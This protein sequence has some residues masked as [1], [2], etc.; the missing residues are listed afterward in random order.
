[1]LK[2][3]HI[4]PNLRKGGAERL[5][6]DICIE[7]SKRENIE[8]SLVTLSDENEYRF[9]SDQI[10][11]KVIPSKVTPSISGKPFVQIKKLQNFI[12]EFKPDVIHSHLFEAEIVSRWYIISGIRYFSHCHDNM[13]QL[14]NFIWKD[15]R[16]KKRI[17]ELYE[18]H[19]LLR[20]YSKCCN[21]FIAISKSTESYL[22][23]VLPRIFNTR[24]Y[25]LANA[26]DFKRFYSNSEKKSCLKLISVGRLDKNKN[27][28]FLF[29]VITVLREKIPV[30][31]TICGD[32][33]EMYNLQKI[34]KNN[35]LEEVISLKG[36]V[37][38]V[39]Y[40]LSESTIYV[41]SSKSEALGLTLLEAMASGLPVVTLNGGGNAYIMENGKNGF[42]IDEQNPELFAEKILEIWE[43]EYL[44]KAM[45]KYAQE[46]S[47]HFDI[48]EYVDKLLGIYKG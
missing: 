37:S 42:I 14:Q 43:N 38:N 33:V 44:Y 5:A 17:T 29:D 1:M 34:L 23:K 40:Y 24:I 20:K 47:K 26:I 13:H 10:N 48:K 27:H 45:R 7:L 19:L 25:L 32:G 2:I 15:L 39:E 18:K 22:N 36:N 6:L 28:R 3:L 8:V 41:H 21:N 16:S 12:N 9:L 46:Y 35:Q 30:H 11:Y 31:L 4:I